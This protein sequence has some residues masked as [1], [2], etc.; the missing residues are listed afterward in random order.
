MDLPNDG[1]A[2]PTPKSK[3]TLPWIETVL[4]TMTYFADEYIE[5][6]AQHVNIPMSVVPDVTL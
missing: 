2:S 1:L 6:R 3:H 5:H 4:K